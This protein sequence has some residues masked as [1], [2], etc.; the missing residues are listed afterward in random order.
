MNNVKIE[1]SFFYGIIYY[2]CFLLQLIIFIYLDIKSADNENNNDEIF[3][4]RKRNA[5]SKL[6]SLCGIKNDTQD[7]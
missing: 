6:D 4:T 3:L 1:D 5:F 7:N 2:Y